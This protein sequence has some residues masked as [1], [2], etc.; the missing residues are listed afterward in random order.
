MP[1][2][3]MLYLPEPF[4]AVQPAG[5]AG[6][7]SRPQDDVPASK[8]ADDAEKAPGRKTLKIL[9]VDDH[10]ESAQVLQWMLESFGHEVH[11][12]TCAET[13]LKRAADLKPDVLFLDL[14]LPHMNG[15]EICRYMKAL[16]G[17]ET[18]LFVAQ[19]GWGEREH[20]ET[21]LQAGFDHHLVKPLHMATLE[22]VLSLFIASR[23]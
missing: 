6:Q 16:P 4:E 2:K 19:T 13:A 22:K 23:S 21:S 1:L 20:H 9:V 14:G 18:S 3:N 17:L 7:A 8:S 11:A 15:Y 5:E 12:S 10:A